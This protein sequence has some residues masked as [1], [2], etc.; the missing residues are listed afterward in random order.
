MHMRELIE[1]LCSDECAGREPG[2][3]GGIA[4]RGIVAE[5]LRR[6]GVEPREQALRSGVGANVVAEVRGTLARWV[7]VGA[8]YDHLGR[9]GGDTYYGADDNAA[10]VAILVEVAR[11]IAA[12][13]PAGRG[14]LFAAFD[15]EEAPHFLSG[16]MGSMGFADDP[17]VPLD[18]IDLMVCMDLVGHA[19]GP[20]SAPDE[21]RDTL[22]ALGAEKSAGTSEI[23]DRMARD[24]PGVFVRRLD[25]DVIPPLSDY[26]AFRQRG[27]PFLFLTCAR[28]RHYHTPEDTPEKLDH[29]KIAATARWLERFVREACLRPEERGAFSATRRDDASTLRTLMAITAALTP[30]LPEATR[31]NAAAAAL[32]PI[33]SVSG[34]LPAS[35]RPHLDALVALIEQG[36]A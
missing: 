36:L 13:P 9:H 7:L 28:W 1:A 5:A 24:E 34:E 32:L 11:G 22:L 14:V 25:V 10:A 19:V 23:V 29:P 2:T 3:P 12:S 31:A 26:H 21:V 15:A 20:S 27:V 8:H 18:A 6:A 4:A 35:A 30:V 17:P 16:T 33:C